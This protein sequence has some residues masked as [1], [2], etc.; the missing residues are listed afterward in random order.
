MQGP[1]TQA[2]GWFPRC[3]VY[4]PVPLCW[5]QPLPKLIPKILIPLVKSLWIRPCFNRSVSSEVK[6]IHQMCVIILL[7]I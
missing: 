4:A 6:G 1:P 7:F 2:T 3:T 5:L